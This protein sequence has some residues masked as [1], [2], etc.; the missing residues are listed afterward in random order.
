MNVILCEKSDESSEHAMTKQLNDM[1]TECPLALSD[2]NSEQNF[3]VE[4]L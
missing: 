3:V 1:V 4:I 2:R